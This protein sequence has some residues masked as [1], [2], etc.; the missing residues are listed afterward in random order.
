LES[1]ARGVGEIALYRGS[2][3]GL[4]HGHFEGLD[5]GEQRCRGDGLVSTHIVRSHLRR[6]DENAE[7]MVKT[8]SRTWGDEGEDV[9]GAIG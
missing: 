7:G 3:K 9:E 2:D 5:G 4:S 8:P 1:K 6:G